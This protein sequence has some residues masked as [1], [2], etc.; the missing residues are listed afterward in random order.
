MADS[1]LSYKNKNADAI[2]QLM[3]EERTTTPFFIQ[4]IVINLKMKKFIIKETYFRTILI[5]DDITIYHKELSKETDWNKKLRLF[6]NCF[7]AL[8]I[9]RD[10]FCHFNMLLKNEKNSQKSLKT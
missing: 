9:L 1:I 6:K 2:A 5:K 4:T 3:I 7:I 10:S 8:D